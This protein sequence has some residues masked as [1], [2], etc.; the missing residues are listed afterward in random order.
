MADGADTTGGTAGELVQMANGTLVFNDKGV[1]QREVEGSSAFNF[2][3][4]AAQGHRIIFDW[5]ESLEEG[6]DGTASATQYGIDSTVARH[7]QDGY[8]AGTLASLTFD[9]N[10]ILSAIFDNGVSRNIAQ[11]AVSKFEN[12]EGLFKVGKNLFK[13]SLRSGQA[14]LG[15]P[16][17][18]GRGQ[19]L[20]KTIELSNVDVANE[21]VS[22]I[23]SQR[24]FS[25]NAKAL[26]TSDEMFKEVLQIKG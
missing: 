16:N 17:E 13:E 22:L 10:G 24:N 21:L 11:I 19:V 14:A 25:A 7:A 1:L 9:N 8:T 20:S 3:K 23:K 6:G 5:G 18:A 26:R 12:N 15:K 4:G 2:N